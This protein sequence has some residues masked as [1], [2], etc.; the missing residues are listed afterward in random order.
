MLHQDFHTQ[1]MLIKY[2]SH[3]NSNYKNEFIM[4]IIEEFL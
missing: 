1:S 3:E 4:F 2:S